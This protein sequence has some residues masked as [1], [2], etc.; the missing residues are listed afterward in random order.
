MERHIIAY[1]QYFNDFIS[2]LDD[3]TREKLLY[4]LLL[5]RTQDRLPVKFIK[6][7]EDGLYE[8]RLKYNTNI[9]RLFFIF[10]GNKMV[11]LFNGFQKKTQ[12]TP[13]KEID[14]ALKLKEEYYAGKRD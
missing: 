1:K 14:K 6:Y 5:L 3:K 4:I 13:R 11:V 2:S 12:K 9:Y 10:D 8:L 7:I